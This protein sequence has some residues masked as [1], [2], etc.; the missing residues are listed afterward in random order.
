M[1]FPLSLFLQE[2]ILFVPSAHLTR[3]LGQFVRYYW[4]FHISPEIVCIMSLSFSTLSYGKKKLLSIE[5]GVLNPNF[6]QREIG[7]IDL[8]QH[9]FIYYHDTSTIYWPRA[10]VLLL[11]C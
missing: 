2:Q 6:D 4:M 1:C 3:G 5:A 10:M 11:K 9:L 8:T 7:S